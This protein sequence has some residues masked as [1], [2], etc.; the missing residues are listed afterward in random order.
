MGTAGQPFFNR[1]LILLLKKPQ[2][3]KSCMDKLLSN[4]PRTAKKQI[5]RSAKILRTET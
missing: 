4:N 3:K 2:D 5:G 1:H